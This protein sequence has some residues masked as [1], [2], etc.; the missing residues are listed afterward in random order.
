MTALSGEGRKSQF[1]AS[2]VKCAEA[3]GPFS[4]QQDFG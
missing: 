2:G 1:P 3:I 4:T